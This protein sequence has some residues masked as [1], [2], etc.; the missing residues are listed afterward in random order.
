MIHTLVKQLLPAHV[1]REYY[2]LSNSRTESHHLPIYFRSSDSP[3][4]RNAGEGRDGAQSVF[5]ID[6]AVRDTFTRFEHNIQSS[7]NHHSPKSRPQ[8]VFVLVSRV[9]CSP[10]SFALRFR[11]ANFAPQQNKASEDRS[12]RLCANTCH[13]CEAQNPKR[14]LSFLPANLFADPAFYF[15][16]FAHV[17]HLFRTLLG[18]SLAFHSSASP[19]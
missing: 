5:S 15:L 16:S 14:F 9:K 1:A 8:Y 7:I 10:N 4:Q 13:T 6:C 11:F 3:F 2:A 19:E 18:K 12:L 17:F